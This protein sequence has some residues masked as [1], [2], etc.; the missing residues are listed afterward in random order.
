MTGCADPATAGAWVLGRRGT[1]TSWAVVKQG[2]DGAVLCA[3]G[4]AAPIHIDALKV[5]P[6]HVFS[7]RSGTTQHCREGEKWRFKIT[8]SSISHQ[9][10]FDLMTL[11]HYGKALI[12]P[13]ELGLPQGREEKHCKASNAR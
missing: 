11:N 4:A 10:L 1:A 6:T 9:L 8:I 7:P 2:G 13:I 12:R 5:P 3:R